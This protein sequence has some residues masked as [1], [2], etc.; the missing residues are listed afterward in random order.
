MQRIKLNCGVT[1]LKCVWC[2]NETE[3]Y[4][5]GY[6][7]DCYNRIRDDIL[8][9]KKRLDELLA[10]SALPGADKTAILE[11]ST[12]IC[13][14][15]DEY[16][17]KKVPFYKSDDQP[18]LAAIYQNLGEAFVLP[19][20]QKMNQTTVT[21]FIAC[22]VLIVSC[23]ALLYQSFTL[24]AQVDNMTAQ[25]SA[26]QA[27]NQTLNDQLTAYQKTATTKKTVTLDNGNYVAGSDFAAGTYDIEAVSGFG[28]VISDN[29]AADGGIN[30][31]MGTKAED[32]LGIA[33]QKYSNI[34]L[35][36]G[37]TLMLSGVKVRLKLVEA[38]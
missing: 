22:A 38:Y 30:A 8:S 27:D 34:K 13:K 5:S 9:N 12:R 14:A 26:L 29:T 16:K 28:N 19:K 6:C 37:T 32:T 10:Q 35:P 24:S 1:I 11:E 2:G 23:V 25:I 4:K 20:K 21:L 33:E 7:E 31:I 36:D 18:T 17:K 3:L 15:L